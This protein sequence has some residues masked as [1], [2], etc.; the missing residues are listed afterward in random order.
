MKLG[1]LVVLN[2]CETLV[3]S[4]ESSVKFDLFWRWD[5]ILGFG[6]MVGFGH[7]GLKAWF[8]DDLISK[9]FPEA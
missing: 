1:G 4:D 3:F 7:V 6:E 5:V 9:W 8:V 2:D